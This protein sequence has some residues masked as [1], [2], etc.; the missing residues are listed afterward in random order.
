[1]VEDMT[2]PSDIEAITGERLGERLRELRVRSGMSLR[3]LARELGISASAV[4]Q[5]ERGTMRPSVSRLIAYVSAIGVPL[6]AVFDE[7]AEEAPREDGREGASGD[8][9][10]EEGRRFAIRR[11]WEVAPITL[12]G[13]VTF[14]RLSPVPTDG[15]EF[16]ESTYPPRAVSAEHGRFLRHEGYEVGTVTRGELTIEFE[17][18][19]VTLAEG[20]S[21]TFPCSRPHIIGNR[22]ATVTA[23]A[24]WLIVHT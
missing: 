3:A 6:A 10:P 12:G 22:S 9:A 1:M 15:V 18:E 8:G 16:F 20:D 5:I 14:R 4:S 11:A 19:V 13:G 24:T 7:K 23:V 17:T 21:I 2:G